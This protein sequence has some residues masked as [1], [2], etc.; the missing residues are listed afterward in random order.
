MK[1]RFITW[2]KDHMRSVNWPLLLFLVLFLNVKLYVKIVAVIIALLVHRE[3]PLPRRIIGQKWLWFY[4]AMP[5]LAGINLLLASSFSIPSLLSFSLG[6]GYWMLAM[7]AGWHVFLFVRDEEDKERLY[8]TADLFFLLNMICVLVVFIGICIDAGSI[9]PFTYRGQHQKYFINTGD[10]F[11]GL[12]MDSSVTAA[13]INA[14]GLLFFLYRGKKG[15]SLLALVCILMAGSNLLDLLLIGCFGFIFLFRSNRVQKLMILVYL[16]LIGVFMVKVSPEN[17]E[18]A[19]H[20]LARLRGEYPYE[21]PPPLPQPKM[22][23]LVEKKEMMV[24][25][26]ALR[27]SIDSLYTR[28]FRDSLRKKYSG[29]D[30]SGRMIAWREMK[31]F[32]LLHPGRLLLGAGMGNFSS[33][34][35]FKTTAMD[36]DGSYPVKRRYIHP[37]FR[38][39]YLYLYLYYHSKDQG[40]HSVVNK[41]D[42]VYGQLLGEYGLVGVACFLLLYLGF[43]I[44]NIRSLTYGLPLLMLMSVCFLT[45]Y[46]FEQLSIVV[47]FE[48][49]MLLDRSRITIE[50]INLQPKDT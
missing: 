7:L 16:V 4:L 14:F 38:D 30:L 22:I 23:D 27:S 13:M 50:T 36:I 33:R 39:N 34:V 45:E 3:T 40:Q 10:F 49:L 19:Q 47:L 2:V 17:E 29:W 5:L 42:S 26:T 15:L 31:D 46:W 9:N 48:F 25:R 11:R 12:S 43:F 35:A 37:F 8:R 44:R 28:S 20:I 41:P 6:C 32:F 18:Y 21:V 24:R 1:E